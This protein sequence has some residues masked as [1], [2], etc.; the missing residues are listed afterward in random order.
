MSPR[1]AR[2]A[3]G[4]PAL[5]PKLTFSADLAAELFEHARDGIFL[6]S[7]EGRF[8]AANQALAEIVGIPRA[9]IIGMTTEVLLPG[10][11]A[12]S[13]QRLEQIIRD[14]RYGPYELEI[15]TP[16]GPKV[17]SLNAFAVHDC[18]VPVGV[19]NIARDVTARRR[20]EQ[21]LARESS[22]V[23][24]LKDVAV[25][26]NQ[27][28]ST[29][30]ALQAAVESVCAATR[31]QVGHVYVVDE[32]GEELSPT[33][34]WN[35]ALGERFEAFRRRTDATRL[36]RGA[37]LPGRSFAGAK[38]VW[39]ADVTRDE[40]VA[41]AGVA[42]EV[43][44]KAGLAFPVL[45]GEEVVA[46]LEFY[47]EED[48]APDPLLLDVLSNLGTQLGRMVERERAA[49]QLAAARDEA[50][51]S[52]RLKASVL[53]NLS[54]EIRTPMNAII[55]MTG[56]LADGQL[57]P[58]QRE[59]VE[60]VRSSAEAL[61][62]LINDILDFSKIEAGR[63]A[64]EPI[65]FDLEM[66]AAEVLDLFSGKAHDKGVDLAA[67][68]A[69]G[70]PRKVVGDPGRIRQVLTN[71][72]G[73]ALKFTDRGQ[74]SIDIEATPRG[75][76][77]A[78]FRFRVADTG[79]GIAP[80]QQ[81]RMFEKFMQADA[82]TTRRY[83]GTGLG[84][85]ISKQLVEVMG[86]EI[87]LSSEPGRG[88]TFWFTLPLPVDASPDVAPA[89]P[90]E[91][92]TLRLLI[93]DDNDLN[94]RILA[95]QLLR[96]NMR[97]SAVASGK[98]ALR[99]LRE[100]YVGGEPFHMAL[101][102][103]H[104]PE[105]DGEMLGRAIKADRALADTVLLLMTSGGQRGDAKRMAEAGFAAYLTKPVVGSVLLDAIATAWAG[106]ALGD[107][108]VLITRHSLPQHPGAGAK[109]PSTD[110]GEPR[111]R[112]LLAEDNPTNQRVARLT[113][114]RLGCR[115]DTAANGKEAVEML[116][117][118]PYDVVFMD[119]QM[120]EMDGYEATREIR[121]REG[122]GRRI[123]IVALTA[124]AMDG[125]RRKCLAAGMDDY[126]SKPMRREA[127]HGAL[128]RWVRQPAEGGAA[129]TAAAPSGGADADLLATLST[130]R[131]EAG[132]EW[133]DDLVAG[134]VRHTAEK[135]AAL[136]DALA[137]GDGGTAKLL[138]HDLKGSAA[139]LGAKSMAGAC[140][141]L[142]GEIAAGAGTAAAAMVDVLDGL[143]RSLQAGLQAASRAPMRAAG[144]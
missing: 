125:D 16:T 28:S 77:A 30:E 123:P 124:H 72:V 29:E 24:L 138:T 22:F 76:G 104:M 59:F 46:V 6:L 33:P 49:R 21:A 97:G 5:E 74:V 32:S 23:R 8:V 129:G 75:D 110:A 4:V 120:P 87:G 122:A 128:R 62:G 85:A 88:S 34:I 134:F 10:K 42:A 94:R 83:G 73:N 64:I 95:E 43:G 1:G 105:M 116:E 79:I 144:R 47:S 98:E 102:D 20:A 140:L 137:R 80:E 136:R 127:V 41:R 118:L 114:E 93:V 25:A 36:R 108:A 67:R 11:F 126:V 117:S 65:S 19:M 113:L 52:A 54:H 35:L 9:E 51:E 18:G 89:A 119:C 143:F 26:A 68:Y 45:V 13:L 50:L 130:L 55:G 135:I 27:A 99:A 91:L 3:P 70:T 131:A 112:V 7:R 115:V 81:A 71:L 48:L 142:E 109:P 12:E 121:R 106:R 17:I 40:S 14:G 39:V 78:L 38:P 57:D 66:A 84:L 63:L 100:A 37:G 103:F 44:L 82:S 60:T 139:V 56:L 90:E 58:E 107:E 133:V 2:Q 111:A 92:Q 86:G 31:W 132:D 15:R 61:L 69:P 101:L 96:W 53:A 141:E